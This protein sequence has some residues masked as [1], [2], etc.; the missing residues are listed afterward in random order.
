M[1]IHRHKIV[2]FSLILIS[3]FVFAEIRRDLEIEA[4]YQ[5]INQTKTIVGAQTLHQLLLN[6]IDN[7]E[8]LQGRQNAIKHIAQDNDL[9]AKLSTLLNSFKQVE[10][11][12]HEISQPLTKIE[13]TFLENL[14]FSHDY[15]RKY[16]HNPL[17]LELGQVAYLGNLCSSLV[18]HALAFA[19]FTWGLE[20]EHT[21]AVHPGKNH[22]HDHHHH[23]HHKHED[24]HHGHK[25]HKPCNHVQ[26]PD[27]I[28]KALAKSPQFKAVFQAWHAIAQIQELYSIQA[29]VR[30]HLKNITAIQSQLM[31]VAAGINTLHQ[32]HTLLEN[33]PEVSNHIAHYQD[34]KNICLSTNISKKLST[35]LKLLKTKT[36]TGSPSAFSRIGI[37]LAAYKLLQETIHEL[38][39]ALNAIG[40]IDAYLNCAQ[41][42]KQH[43]SDSLP[44]SFAH[45]ITNSQT[46]QLSA[47]QIWHPLSTSE[48]IQ[49]NS[50]DLG[51]NNQPR[52]II[53]TGPNA[54]GKSTTLKAITLCAYLGQTL[55]IVPA[56]KYSQ[57]ICKEIYSSMIVT[58]SLSE[59]MSLF[60]AELNNAQKLLERVE[61]LQPG[62]YIFIA[63]DE[64]FKSTHYAKGQKVA[65]RLLEELYA[66]PNVITVVATHFEKLVELA[67]ENNNCCANYTVDNFT[68][69]PGIGSPDKAF[70]IVEKKRN[71]RLL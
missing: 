71:N 28:F 69:K 15:L 4:F 59:D 38:Q 17:Y 45:Y 25:K 51:L 39:P 36:F 62:E 49:L 35:C 10:T 12:L 57:T 5:H 29:V 22:S 65:Y 23:H 44:Y 16:N 32:I 13:A 37:I 50:I 40:E 34:L 30:S 70:E 18:Q 8:T 64:L 53:V 24:K 60:V 7:L 33:N 21:C 3:Q 56:Q 2:G 14:Y 55:T 11:S 27:N 48:N 47:H 31:E 66:S 52:N 54:C 1:S 58:D 43:E 67:D 68:L 42:I 41:L 61:Q 20:Q 26:T 6:P 46:P 19:I 9:C 63:L